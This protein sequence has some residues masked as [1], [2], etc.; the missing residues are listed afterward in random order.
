MGIFDNVDFYSILDSFTD[1]GGFDIILPFLLIFAVTFALLQK[2]KLFGE[3]EKAKKINAIVSFVLAFFLIAQTD[4]VLLL[5][6][7]LP[8]ISMIIVVLLMLLLVVGI[9]TK[10]TNW[11]GGWLLLGAVV[12]IV[13]VIW[14]IGASAGWDVPLIDEITEG[15]I[16][17]L[18]SLG[19]F[20]LVIWLIVKDPGE[21]GESK[22]IGEALEGFVRGLKGRS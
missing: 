8:K 13:A 3:E 21:K 11:D 20:I 4:L 14:A 10:N 19:V 6:S 9:F 17:V 7:F 18:I 1:I 12:A 16:G 2:I 5:Q 15:D 22:G